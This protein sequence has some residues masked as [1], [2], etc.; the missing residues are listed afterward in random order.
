[1]SKK[2]MI[3]VLLL[4]ITSPVFSMMEITVEADK[5]IKNYNYV[6]GKDEL[7]L[8][9]PADTADA[10]KG[11]TELNVVKRGLSRIQGDIMIT[12]GTYEQAS[13]MLDGIRINDPQTGHYNLDIPVT[14]LDIESIGVITTASP[15]FGFGAFTG[16]VSVQSRVISKDSVMTRAEYGTYNTWSAA[17]MAAKKV[18]DFKASISAEKAG[19]DGYWP[20]TDFIKNTAFFKAGYGGNILSLAYEDKN[21][22]AYDFYTPG[23]NMPSREFL[24]TRYAALNL[25]PWEFLSVKPYYRYHYDKFILNND[26][27]SYYQN[28]HN[29]SLYGA[30]ADMRLKPDE[31]FEIRAK[32]GLRREEI[33]SSSF[34]NHYRAVGEADIAAAISLPA[35]FKLS[36]EGA[37]ISYNSTAQTDFLRS[38]ML[39][40]NGL[41]VAKLYAGCSE[42]ARYPSFT[43]L[44]YN[45]PFTAGNDALKPERN[46]DFKAGFDMEVGAIHFSVE[47]L[48]RYSTDLIDWGK[49]DP[50]D[51]KWAADNIGKVNTGS[52]TSALKMPLAVFNIS[53]GHTYTDS[54][55]S[56]SYI[57]K[58][59]ANY[60]RNKFFTSVDFELYGL[61]TYLSYM[62][63]NYDD[64]KDAYN[65]FDISVSYTFM[66]A[67]TA[68]IKCENMAN[69]Y[70]EEIKGIPAPG[71][72]LKVIITTQF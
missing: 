16:L 17:V 45:D 38:A 1:M 53:A 65:S 6:L 15:Y 10:I 68:M 18:N 54:Y 40:W 71:R 60:L 55:A 39:E 12:A 63:K 59:G 34:K 62:Y 33:Q 61:I 56:V 8:L 26:N 29:T 51:A 2:I 37:L 20:E 5:P 50:G 11:I 57:S 43:E 58:Y 3:F 28:R 48:Y 35:D 52:V 22:G 67:V 49:N 64:R 13:V 42:S 7:S 4:F 30:D 14:S 36:A 31:N 23:R 69:M 70:Y 9:N 72:V 19:S 46:L 27:P 21:Y 25:K 47:G 24:I 32:T 66:E 44:Y 41:E